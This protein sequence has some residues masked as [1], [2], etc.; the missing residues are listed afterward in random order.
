MATR[1]VAP[2]EIQP[3][4]KYVRDELERRE[5][6]I[7]VNFISN[8]IASWDENGNWNTY[9][10]PMRC[11]VRVC[12]NGIGEAKYGSKEG[13]VMSGATGF[14][15]DYGID[16][17]DYSKTQTVLGYTPSGQPHQ[18]DN[19]Y[20]ID[21][22]A[23]SKHVPPPGIISIDATMQK[24]MYRQVTIK[25]KCFSKDH[26]NYMTP[27]F[28]S[29]GVSTFIEW[30]WNHYNP[31]CLL[32][33]NN[34]GQPAK[35]KDSVDD[36][37]PGPSGDPNDPRKTAGTGLL[38][39]YTDPLQQQ[40]LVEDGK[41]TY[42]LTCGIITSFDYSLQPDGSYD[43]TTEIKSNSFIYS[44]VQ[45]RSNALAST[46]PAD[47]KGNKKPEPV[48]SF[49]E[50]I[51]TSFKSIPKTVLTGLNSKDPL[52]P[53]PVNLPG[54]E[55]RV[56]IPRNLDTSNDPRTKV[57]NV[58]KYSF[59]SGATDDFWITM[60]LFIDLINKFF[61]AESPKVGATFN[62]IDISSSWIGGH[63]NLIS[64][65]GKILLIPNS[66]APNI[67]PS[68]EDRG[69]S[70]NYTTPDTQK[71]GKDAA[72]IS[73]ADKT[74]QSLFNSTTRQDLNEIINYF[75]IKYSGKD[76][77]EVEFPAKQYD[78]NL[79]KLE[80]LYVHKDV[81]LKAVEKSETVTDILN[82][83]LNKVSE[84]VNGMWKFSLIQYGPSNSLLSIIDTECFSLKRLQELNSD[85]RPYIYFFKNRASRNNIQSLNFSVKLSDKVATTVL[86][87]SPKDNKTSVPMK[88][89]FGFVTRD[90][91]F[92]LTN[93]DSYLTPKDKEAVLKANQ[94]TEL[95]RQREDKKRQESIQKERDVKA[96]A[97]IVGIVTREG[98]AEKTYIRKL[99]LTQK[100]LF[101]LLVNDKDPY[102]SSI[103]SFPQPGIKAEITLTGIAGLKTFQVFGI[104]N[105]PE[106]YDKDILFQVEDV[107]HSLQSNGTW[108]TTVTAG[109]RPTKG[110]NIST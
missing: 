68:V 30:G 29:P 53:T 75:R 40:L 36:K 4:P 88:N 74:L 15:K 42:E 95:E 85:K 76:P 87:N 51:D 78:Y 2:F 52:F 86:Y 106:P 39:I 27:Y 23:I 108:T 46:S 69:K 103:N 35:M 48:K 101:T 45:T 70:T 31:K 62:Q 77:A 57:D 60:G 73:E 26:L 65:D 17:S 97:F 41:G 61:A 92:Q 19:E 3:I 66:Q 43:C 55:T 109:I 93:D 28:M 14:Y 67:S 11:W 18:I 56:F 34:V 37:T 107:K 72:A 12:S 98:G 90:R 22:K 110:L 99:V 44:G 24:S 7:G 6:D 84:A 81:I 96:G 89:P 80:N 47:N 32:D 49:K 16:P 8:I 21:S 104:D 91:F 105:L 71:D 79:G 9:K 102:N 59:D 13:F 20:T 64:T 54:P 10:G 94:N 1:F 100:D 5:R 38:G 33:L 50:Y 63:K 58:T 25:W 83:V 82:F